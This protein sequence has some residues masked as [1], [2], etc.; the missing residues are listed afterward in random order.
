MN[1]ELHVQKTFRFQLATRSKSHNVPHKV[2]HYL[3]SILSFTPTIV[4]AQ[5]RRKT[6]V[7]YSHDLK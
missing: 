1:W 6:Y 2:F 3:I 4:M 5:Q 7:I